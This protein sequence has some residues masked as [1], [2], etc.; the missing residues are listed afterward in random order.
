MSQFCELTGIG[1]RSG[2]LVSH[3]NNK[4]RTRWLPNIT[5]KRYII[6]E[7]GRSITLKISANGIK[8]I[9]KQGGIANAIF[10]AREEN[11]SAR[12]VKIKRSLEKRKKP[13]IK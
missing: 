10:K 5:H 2:N 8:T 4:N 12:L 3:A 6:E 7:I 11:L 1:P 9:Q 13:S